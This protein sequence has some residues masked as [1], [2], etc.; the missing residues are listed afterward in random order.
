M[1]LNLIVIAAHSVVA[2]FSRR[3]ETTARAFQRTK[4]RFGH[5]SRRGNL[6]L[7]SYSIVFILSSLAILPLVAFARL[8]IGICSRQCV[9]G[10]VAHLMPSRITTAQD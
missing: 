8:N 5:V 1:L 4:R 7:L 2:F 9:F 3:D 6:R 10:I